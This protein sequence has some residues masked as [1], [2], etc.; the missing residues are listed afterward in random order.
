[1]IDVRL[2]DVSAEVLSDELRRLA[3]RLVGRIAFIS[4]EPADPTQPGPPVVRKPIRRTTLLDLLG[5][6]LTGD[7]GFTAVSV[8][9]LN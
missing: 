3:P 8:R 5:A 9:L 7:H 6:M 4:G 1:L 2:P